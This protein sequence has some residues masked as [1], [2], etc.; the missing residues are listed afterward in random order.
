M[1]AVADS[2][3]EGRSHL[4]G[5]IFRKVAAIQATAFEDLLTFTS[6]S[7]SAQIHLLEHLVL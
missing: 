7:S 4:T 6:L 5:I 2:S 3:I 1:E